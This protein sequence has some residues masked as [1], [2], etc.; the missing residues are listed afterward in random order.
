MDLNATHG[1]IALIVLLLAGVMIPRAIAAHKRRR[2][3]LDA[4]YAANKPA[5]GGT[6]GDADN[7]DAK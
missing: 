3:A 5:V 1:L 6:D 7:T 2:A 4:K